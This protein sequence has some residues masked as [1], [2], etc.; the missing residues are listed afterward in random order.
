M[1]NHV[2][3]PFFAVLLLTQH[4]NDKQYNKVWMFFINRYLRH[5]FPRVDYTTDDGESYVRTDDES[6]TRTDD[7]DAELYDNHPKVSAGIRNYFT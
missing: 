6:Y 1:E 5:V 3:K 7:E 4:A 2:I